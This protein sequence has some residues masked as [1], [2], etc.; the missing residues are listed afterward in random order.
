MILSGKE[1][2][3]IPVHED[4]SICLALD[5]T[6]VDSTYF[7][8]LE[9]NTIVLLLRAGQRWEE[10]PGP[11]NTNV[12]P[13]AT[14]RG[15]RKSPTLT[16]TVGW[17]HYSFT[18]HKYVLAK[19]SR[20]HPDIGPRPVQLLRKASYKELLAEM[21]NIFFKKG[22][23]YKGH[24][25]NM[26]SSLGNAKGEVVIDTADFTL[27]E[28]ASDGTKKRLYLLTKSQLPSLLSDSSDSSTLPDPELSSD[29]DFEDEHSRQLPSIPKKQRFVRLRSS[30]HAIPGPSVASTGSPVGLTRTA[31]TN[32]ANSQV[33]VAQLRSSSHAIPGPSVASTGSPVGLTRTASTNS[34]N[35]QVTVAQASLLQP[36]A[37]ANSLQ[38]LSPNLVH[39]WSQP[40]SHLMTPTTST[41]QCLTQE[42]LSTLLNT[43]QSTPLFGRQYATTLHISITHQ[44]DLR[45]C[46]LSTCA[47]VQ[48]PG[49]SSTQTVTPT[50]VFR[51][52]NEICSICC[53]RSCSAL[54]VPC[55]HKMCTVCAYQIKDLGQRCPHCRGVICSIESI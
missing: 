38:Q 20:N 34:A 31:S 19:A 29:S 37:F 49:L 18:A 35:S 32:S 55:G 41:V 21:T 6:E 54:I 14:E 5:G 11:S 13:G 9:R 40:G 48:E 30:S 15:Q 53:E 47:S 28:Y 36:Q 26:V 27:E 46:T 17:Q 25:K 24:I 45:N 4:V 51:T 22:K 50:V 33:T 10:S 12:T 1:K 7:E 52:G 42:A 23:N 3:E 8:V 39:S 2:F 16:V 43:E 44:H